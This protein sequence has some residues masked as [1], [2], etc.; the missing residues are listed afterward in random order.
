MQVL[1]CF[2]INKPSLKEVYMRGRDI[3]EI[4]EKDGLVKRKLAPLIFLLFN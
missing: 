1:R 3:R 2:S 4:S